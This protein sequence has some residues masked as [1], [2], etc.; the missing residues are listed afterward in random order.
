MKISK[1]FLVTCA[2]IAF[3]GIA[4]NRSDAQVKG[5]LRVGFFTSGSNA[6]LGAGLV[7]RIAPNL[8]LNPMLE[9]VFINGATG[10]FM[11]GDGHYDFHAADNADVWIGG[12]LGVMY[13]KV[14]NFSDTNI[15]LNLLTGVAF[16]THASVY[17]YFQLK[18]FL[19]S[20][21][22]AQLAIGLRF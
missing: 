17:P 1:L 8:Y 13:V 4:N 2:A 11:S 16:A 12:G 14:N 6:S 7:A 22:N 21:T 9:Y 15:G 18:G 5:D 20:N 10:L 19:S 3:I